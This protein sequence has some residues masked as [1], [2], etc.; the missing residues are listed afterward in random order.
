VIFDTST[1]TPAGTG[2]Q[3]HDHQV[4]NGLDNCITFEVHEVLSQIPGNELIYNFERALQAPALEMM[5]RGL[6]VDLVARDALVD[7][8]RTQQSR[9]RHIL[10]RYGDAI[11]DHP[12]GPNTSSGQWDLKNLFYQH[13]NLPVQYKIDKG[14]KK[15]SCGREALEKLQVYFHAKPICLA[16]LAFRDIS[17]QI[18]F[19]TSKVDSDNRLRTSY[20][21]AGT[22]TGRWSSSTN[23]FGTGG[24]NQ[25]WPDKLRRIFIPDEGR[26]FAYCDLEQA[27]S[28]IAGIRAWLVTGQDNYIRAIR[29]GD[30]HTYVSRLVWPE[31]PWNG[32][33]KKDREIAERPYYRDYSY[34]DLGKRGGHG[35][36]YYGT[37][38]TMSKHLKVERRIMELFQ[39]RYFT[40]FPELGGAWNGNTWHKWVAQR[41]Q[42]DGYLTTVLGRT[43]HFFGRVTDDS[44]LREA[45]AY[46]PQSCVADL[47]NLGAWRIWKHGAERDVR[48]M[49]QLHDAVLIEYPDDPAS[50]HEV[51]EFVAPLLRTKLEI[52][53]QEFVIPND[54]SSGWNWAKFNDKPERG[55]LNPGG[56]R[57]LKGREDRARPAT[58]G[59]D[60]LI[61]SFH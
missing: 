49:A 32:D 15:P 7:H 60:R 37:P 1:L 34:R 20:N 56:V 31:L 21:I 46:E 2:D 8:L 26:K 41:L 35:T 58:T 19:L 24:N 55:P 40:A 13:M 18:S 54:F 30:L 5:L 43:R 27:E 36:N 3:F 4:Y 57:K 38:L 22:E 50:E 44:T 11:W 10:D 14:V 45:I 33:L 25:N 61:P 16:I 52:G 47:L 59:L 29:S 23:A 39:E 17:K 42:L 51:A 53:G 9:L 6:R 12:I 28:W 48:L